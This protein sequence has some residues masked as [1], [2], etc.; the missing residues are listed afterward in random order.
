M[1]L[2]AGARRPI[3]RGV[4]RRNAARLPAS[5]PADSRA[6]RCAGLDPDSESGRRPR[7]GTVQKAR[8]SPL[9]FWCKWL[10]VFH[11]ANP[12]TGGRT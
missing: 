7:L 8:C 2:G 1:S 5:F 9:E 10:L 3:R 11:P 4:A 6:G 12:Y